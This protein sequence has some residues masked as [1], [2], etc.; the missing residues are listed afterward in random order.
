M[1]SILADED[2]SLRVVEELRRLGHDVVTIRAL[3]LANRGVDDSSILDA[4]KQ[5]VRAVVTYNRRHFGR[6][7]L[8]D[9]NHAGI[10]ICTRD[11]DVVR[12]ARRIHDAISA[13]NSLAGLLIRIT[14]PGPVEQ[15]T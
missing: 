10:I 1:V 6:L 4:A 7:H 13:H 11:P 15:Q 3:G 8:S 2:F 14:R 12:Q 5:S 9:A